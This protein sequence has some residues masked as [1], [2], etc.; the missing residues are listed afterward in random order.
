MLSISAVKAL[1]GSASAARSG[2][3]PIMVGFEAAWSVGRY[4]RALKPG[5]LRGRYM[6]MVTLE[7]AAALETP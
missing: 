6:G 1:M 3:G 5:N 4:R 2:S 7:S